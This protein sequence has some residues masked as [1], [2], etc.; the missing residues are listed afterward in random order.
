MFTTV[1]D[2]VDVSSDPIKTNGQ[3]NRLN[4]PADAGIAVTAAQ[5]LGVVLI[6]N[7]AVAEGDLIRG[8][9]HLLDGHDP[10]LLQQYPWA[11]G[12]SVEF[13]FLHP[14]W[15]TPDLIFSLQCGFILPPLATST[16][17]Q[18]NSTPESSN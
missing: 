6:V 5:F 11:T 7:F 1:V 15:T 13:E 10:A 8:I 12:K 18:S 16:A 2:L 9:T 17:S 3:E 4:I 14:S